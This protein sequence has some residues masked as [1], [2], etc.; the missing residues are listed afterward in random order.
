[1]P[2]DAETAEDGG[3]QKT[4]VAKNATAV[5]FGTIPY[6]EEGT[7]K[8]TITETKGNLP[9]VTYDTDAHEV[10]VTV[11]KDRSN[12]LVATVTYDEGTDAQK[13]TNTFAAVTKHFEATKE[14]N[15]WGTAESFTFTLTAQS[16]ADAPM[17]ETSGRTATATK[18]HETAVFGDITYEA[19]GTYVYVIKETD[20][21]VPGITYDTSEHI[22]TVVVSQNTDTNKLTA[23]VTYGTG[24]DASDSLTIS[25]TFTKAQAE[26]KATKSINDWGS[27]ESFTFTL[28]PVDG[29]PMPD[30]AATVE[31]TVTKDG[32]LTA[33]FGTIKYGE[34]GQYKYTITETDGGVPGVTYDTTPHQ[35]IVDVH[36]ASDSNALV[37]DVTYDGNSS[38]TITNRYASA[39]LALQATKSINDW[40]DAT[41]FTFKLAAGK[42]TVNGEEGT[43]PMPDS[44][45]AT[46]TKNNMTALFGSVKYE[47]AGTYNYTITEVDD[48]VAGI[49]YD[50]T[51]HNVVVTVERDANGN[52]VASAK[53]D[54]QD[55][56]T[57]TNTFTSLKK[58]LEVTKSIEE[59]GEATS[60]TFKLAAAS[61][62]VPMPAS[63]TATVT[64][65]GSMKAVFGEIE[66]KTTGEYDYTITEQNDGV[67]GVTYDTTPH[68]VH[69]SVTKNATTNALEAT[70]TYGEGEDA[71]SSLTITNT[72]TAAEAELK[73]TKEFDAWGKATSFTFD[74][75]AV[76]AVDAEGGAIS[77]I[78]VPDSMTATATQAAKT[79]SFGKIKYNQ[80]GTYTYTITEQNGGADGV[81]Y[82]TTP[83]TVVVTV[84]KDEETNALSASV[85]YDDKDSLTIK[86]TYAST[87]ATIEATKEFNDWGKATEFKFDLAAVTE[88]A[89]MPASTTATATEQKPL[90]SFGE[91][92]YE[93]AGVYEYTITERNGGADGVT[94][95]TTAHS[96][97]VT[98][99]KAN[100]ATNKLTATVKYGDADS[101]TIT[102][103][104]TSVKKELE[105]TKQ[106]N[107]WGTAESFTFTLKA[108]G[109]APMPAGTK[110]GAKSVDVTKNSPLAEFGEIEYEAAGTYEYTITEEKGDADGVTYDTTAHTAVVTVAKD[111]ATNA[112][113]ATVKYDGEDALT[114]TNKYAS[115]NVD[116]QATKQFSDW[117]KA[118]SFTFTLEAVSKDAPMPEGTNEGK[119]TATATSAATT[120]NFGSITYKN[121]GTYEYTITET[122]DGKDG[123]TYD[124]KPHKVIVTVTKDANNKLVAEAKY[125]DKDSLTITNTY[126]AA[127]ATLEATKSFADWGKADSFTFNL[128]AVDG[129]PMPAG[130]EEGKKSGIATQS[131][132]VV[133]FGEI[134]FEKAGTYEYTITEQNGGADGV[135]YDTTPH[136]VVVT[137]T[138]GEGNKLSAEVKYDDAESLTITNTYASTKATI[139]ATKEFEDWGKAD[140]FKFDLAAVTEGAPM[141][142]ETT[143]T[144]TEQNPLASFGEI[145]YE[146]AGTYEYTITEQ[147]GGADGVTYDTTAHKVK[148]TVNKANDA[149]NKLTATVTYDGKA[150]LIITNTYAATEATLE[151]TKDFAD[152]GKADEFKFD[153]AAVTDGAPMPE[154]TTATATKDAPLASFGK[155]TYEKA[156]TYEY[157]I[158][159]QN[160]G[161][162]GVTYDTKP[163]KVVVTVS[164]ANDAT[165]KLTATVKYDDAASLTITNT[166]TSTKKELE[167]TKQLD[168]WGTA[169][170][171]TFTLEAKGDAPMPADAAEGKKSVD[172]T[173][174]AT[175]AKFGE[176]EYEK[177]GTYEYTI[178]EEKGDADGVTYDTTA[179]TAVVT[180]AKDPDTN[181]LSAA[182]KYDGKDTLIITNRYASSN[183]ELQATKE[184]NGWGKA[185]S[186]TFTLKP[187]SKDAPMPE[188]TNDA[189]EKTATATQ[190]ATT[191]K[192]G[193][194]TYKKAGTYEYTITETDDGKDGV[195][196]DTTP[197][198]V[199]VTVTKDADNKLVAVAKYDDKDNLII[200]NTYEAT[201]ATLEATKS[202]A[203]WGKADSFTFD[204]E[205]VGNAPMPAGA[206]EGKKSGIATKDAPV[207]NFGE[208]TY[209]KAGTYEYTITEQN[210]GAD[211]VTYDTTPHNV[212]VTVTKGKGNK[213]SAEVK[214]DDAK[215][216]TI[217]NTYASTKATIEATKEFEDW[218]KATEFKFDLAAVTEGAPMPSE[219]TATATEK[220]PLASFGEITYEKAGTYEY[221]ITEQNSGADGVTYDTTAHKVKVVVTKANDATNKLTATVTYDGKESL[222]ITN[223]YEATSAELKA[224][225]EFNDWG[226]ADSFTFNLA[227]VTKD[228]P[229]PAK[230]SAT[231]TK[232]AAE[233]SFGNITFEK[234]GTYEYT[235]T[236]VNDGVDGVSYDTTAHKAVVTVSKAQGTNKLSA[237]VKYDG[238]DSLTITNTFTAAEA[239]LEATKSFNDWGKAESF[240]FDLAAVTKDAPM[241]EKTEATATKNNVNAVFGKVVY[242][243]AGTYEYTITERNGGVDGVTYDTTAHKVK[244]EVTKADD[245][246]NALTA[247]VTY[248]GDATLIV[249]NTYAGTSVTLQATKE[250]NDWGKADSF[251]FDLAAVGGAPMPENNVATA[252]ESAKTA[253]FGSIEYE[254]TGKYE[255]TITER[256]DG[257]DGVTYDTKAH[258]VVVNVTKDANNKMTAKAA[259]DGKDNLTIT[260]TFTSVKAHF[261]TTKKFND[262]G[263]TES[264]TFDLAAVTKG[265]PMPAETS[266]TA[267]KGKAAVFGDMEF[268][269]AGTYEYTITEQNDGV[270]GVSY[271]VTPHKATVVVTKDAETNELSAVVT[272][273]GEKSLTITNT[274]E[275][276]KAHIEATKVFEGRDWANAD[277]FE[278]ELAAKTEGAPLPKVTT[279]KATKNNQTAVFGDM[280]FVKA[281]DY[282]YTV[283]EKE[284]TNKGITYDT[285]PHTVTVKVTKAKDATNKLTATVDYGNAEKLEIKNTYSAT[286]DVEL[287]AHKKLEGETGKVLKPEQFSFE[288]DH[289]H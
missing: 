147:N 235:I 74:L 134:T 58:Q 231:A 104:Y 200:T 20:D 6:T 59:W 217:T 211:G 210:G 285:A 289:I 207:V 283:T 272:Y 174:N 224:T 109:N 194:I 42:S 169:K 121:A 110:D 189:G 204:L 77:P 269:K 278:F 144:A 60:F 239:A 208:I 138:K 237:S 16:P 261:E 10:T 70:V 286:G 73:A 258:K 133:N 234:A 71:G 117:G 84:S 61:K 288:Q 29:S 55:S 175:L 198:K 162:D 15:N 3:K 14:I 95:D 150:S 28:A 160:G 140:E 179:H 128:E 82:D 154:S 255:Y 87:K 152:W 274:F 67:D 35:V 212:V 142:S 280:E 158:T 129:A 253:V 146:K 92:T 199:V 155:I 1:M 32:D 163:H 213:L 250:F 112:L 180:V 263:K 143:A 273:D 17:P 22:V 170:S 264:F 36:K 130:T 176:I 186:F 68:P 40:G 88:G 50:T 19:P 232:D 124:T 56:L 222:T 23:A 44:D 85:K 244:V 65:G 9:G 270:D 98:V 168:D 81:S 268:D 75:A 157:T 127:K 251:T 284:G 214:Y 99:A 102:N 94:Y 4:A 191:A 108:K 182:V 69:V 149:T 233:A 266:A 107:D 126:E 62:G 125:D 260:N 205:A 281:G 11:T 76:S 90:A 13:I 196:Y 54:N 201:K 287:E 220:N 91:I 190:A 259:Y 7:Y 188:G 78:P 64:K 46:A 137:V 215:S 219:T 105:A 177:A 243:K 156:G 103:T 51:P 111:P 164:K 52:L 49:T 139:E 159:E 118:D 48:H 187:V 38:L 5:S 26:L 206:A 27:A 100:D 114:I 80:A 173:E 238:K 167:A 282:E 166:Y 279:L 226:K 203:D 120:A 240:T 136:N 66:Y 185:D 256:N 221:T 86:N 119:K 171:F 18:G 242:D 254:K 195:T 116:L 12:H 2:S 43:S 132:P 115:A 145:E 30:D 93:K 135:T 72:F 247:K 96:V 21:H 165:N 245:A 172:V 248:D 262:W 31:K 161:A 227:A 230:T 209:E 39:N 8:Y 53:Y 257:V 241:P 25:N 249:T 202:F 277:E 197:H 123:V 225:K 34:I 79:A 41:S 101:L 216:L 271:D 183:V 63:D 141:P 236:E 265:A 184:F 252:T 131:T 153:L 37:A 24:E 97:T 228:A 223:T 33:V 193:K 267:T 113:S 89:P 45:T 181:A 83:H 229:M 148:V 106:I 276:V 122:D 218:G 57:I 151:A 178:T 275:S 192:F 246:T 47:E